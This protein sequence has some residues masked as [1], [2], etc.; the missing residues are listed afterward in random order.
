MNPRRV[1]E[2]MRRHFPPIEAAS[3]T[4]SNIVE[5]DGLQAVALMR[6]LNQVIPGEKVLVWVHR[7]LGDYLSKQEAVSFVAANI[8]HGEIRIAD[9]A[10]RG[11]V[12]VAQ[13]GVA[14]GWA[15]TN[16]ERSGNA[17]TASPG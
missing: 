11:L 9:R 5:R 3:R 13:N 17:T 10:F 12:V 14:T 6:L 15:D 7:T 8:C 1:H 4:W 2:L 16:N